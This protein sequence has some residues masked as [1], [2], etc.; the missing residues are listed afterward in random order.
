[1]EIKK[2]WIKLRSEINMLLQRYWSDR[3]RY[4]QVLD[5]DQALSRL[6]EGWGEQVGGLGVPLRRDDA[7]RFHLLSL[8]HQE[9]SAQKENHVSM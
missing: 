1:M 6:G 3:I 8:F 7:G 9:S 5:T 4:Q 2:S